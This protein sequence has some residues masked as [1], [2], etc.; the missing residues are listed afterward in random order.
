[1]FSRLF[2][3]SA[4]QTICHYWEFRCGNG[5]QC[6]QRYLLC[7]GWRDCSDGSD[8][9]SVNCGMYSYGISAVT[10]VVNKDSNC[11]FP[12]KLYSEPNQ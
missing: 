4:S 3:F 11:C 9:W 12:Y 2:S 1:M 8:E 6:V 7:N 10:E 5:Y